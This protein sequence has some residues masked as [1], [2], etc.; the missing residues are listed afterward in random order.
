MVSASNFA[1]G[2]FLVRGL[3]LAQF[4]KYTIAYAFLLYA[5][6][7]QLSF[8]ASPML[9]LAPLMA[10]TERRRFVEG[11]LGVQ[12]LASLL[13]FAIFAL[14]GSVARLFTHFYSLPCV[15]AFASCVG[16]FQMQDWLRRYYFL[17]SRGR[18]AIINDFIS[19]VVQLAALAALW[20]VHGLTLFRTFLVMCVT[21]A[22]ASAMGPFTDRLSPT[23]ARLR[24]AWAQC[25]GLSLDLLIVSQVRWFGVQGVLLI[26]TAIV[27]TAAAGGLR[28]AQNLAGPV[29]LILIATENVFP[30]RIAEELAKHGTA[31]AYALVQ[32]AIW[33]GTAVFGLL[34]IPIS[35]FGRS[36]L[37]LLYGPPMVAFYLPMLLQLVGIVVQSAITMWFYFYRGVRDTRALL[38][39][40]ALCAA[41]DVAAV[42]FF[43]RLWQAPGIVLAS[44]LGQILTVGYCMLYWSRHRE[45]LLLRYPGIKAR[46]S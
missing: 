39:A 42:Y 36:L 34:V 3:G 15:F 19:Y 11:M 32:R 29:F 46:T 2:I 37:H 13:L 22:A 38:Q 7:L 41:A 31:G 21:S 45:E 10:A 24:G 43:G 6:S 26:G 5:N 12:L 20:R 18:L 44:L 35:I 33:V 40:S 28:A 23:V 8:V 4:G 30:M 9:S 16:T 25:K 17:H 27:G 14:V 1:T